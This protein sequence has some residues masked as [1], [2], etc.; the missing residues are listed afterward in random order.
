MNEITINAGTLSS[1]T[2]T[3]ALYA[4]GQKVDS[5]NMIITK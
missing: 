3:Y 4:D 5:K 1:G 2:Y